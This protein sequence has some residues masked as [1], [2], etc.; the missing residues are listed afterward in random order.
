MPLLKFQKSSHVSLC[1]YEDN[2]VIIHL[3]SVQCLFR[4]GSITVPI[5]SINKQN[6]VKQN[7]RIALE[8]TLVLL[9][10][11][12]RL[13]AGKIQTITVLMLQNVS[14]INKLDSAIKQLYDNSAIILFG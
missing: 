12:S 5:S 9:L 7:S 1:S 6:K 3:K 14:I 8:K 11:L 13:N 4:F 10:S 2:S